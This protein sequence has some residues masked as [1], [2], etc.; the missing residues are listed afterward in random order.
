MGS[1]LFSVAF[2]E[3]V[4]RA[5]A[6][7][8]VSWLA[9]YRR[10]P[11]LPFP[12]LLPDIRVAVDTGET[13]WLVRTDRA[14]FRI[15]D[16]PRASARCTALWLGDSFAFG[17][18]VDWEDSLV[19]LVEA[20][21]RAMRQANAAVPGYGPVQYRQVLEYLLGQGEEFRFIFVVTYVGNDFHDCLW[22]RD[23]RVQDGIIGHRGDLRSW[24]KSHLHLYRL[25]SAAYHRLAPAPESPY[26]RTLDELA[27]PQAWTSGTLARAEQ[28]FV[29][30][31]TRIRDLARA[32]GAEAR[33]LILPT[34]EAVAAARGEKSEGTSR[35]LL[36][37]SRA[38]SALDEIDAMVFDATGVLAADPAVRVYFPFD[39]HLD[40]E[41]N[42]R[43]ADGLLAAWSLDCS[44]ARSGA[45]GDHAGPPTAP[46]SG[47]AEVLQS[48]R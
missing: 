20:R 46:T 32:A 18:G 36:P 14:G 22:N 31:L 24:L 13:R 45:R 42:R 25:A 35:A 7:Q 33:F 3:V 43:V 8:P 39:G 23:V 34:Q 5:L 12:G 15:G 40:R 48:P 38:R 29:R 37:V 44:R 6:P 27:D 30:E 4:L 47:V 26:Q 9:I 19:G 16:S 2:G 41:G 1:A 28:I 10:H 17:H 11:S 21:V